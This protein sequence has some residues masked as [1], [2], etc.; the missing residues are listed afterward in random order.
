VAHLPN[1]VAVVVPGGHM[2]AERDEPV[3]E[4]LGWLGDADA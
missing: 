1:A 2:S 3:E 4:L